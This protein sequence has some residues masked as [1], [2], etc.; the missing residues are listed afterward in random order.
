M[1]LLLTDAIVHLQWPDNM[2][3]RAE[4]SGICNEL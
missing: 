1:L 2:N 4:E 3:G